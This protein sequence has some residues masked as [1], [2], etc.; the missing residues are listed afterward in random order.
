MR[1]D[2]RQHRLHDDAD[3]LLEAVAARQQLAVAAA[4]SCRCRRRSGGLAGGETANALERPLL[5]QLRVA[6]V[7]VALRDF[8]FLNARG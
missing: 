5:L 4:V 2:P 6:A 8:R 3:V 7:Q 1:G